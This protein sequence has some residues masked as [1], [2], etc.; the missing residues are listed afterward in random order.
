MSE[1]IKNYCR[2][3]IKIGDPLLSKRLYYALYRS[4]KGKNKNIAIQ[5]NRK[6]YLLS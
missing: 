4:K 1:K 5:T 3:L 2:S 6:L